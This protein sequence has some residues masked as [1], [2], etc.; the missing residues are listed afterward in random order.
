MCCCCL[1]S[2]SDFL[3]YIIALIFPPVAVLL[4]S[5][6]ASVDL[7]LNVCLTLL[8]FFPGLIHAFYYITMTSPIRGS[9][10]IYE[11]RWS[12]M[13]RDGSQQTRVY[14][15]IDEM[16]VPLNSN[17]SIENT[18]NSSEPEGSSNLSIEQ[19]LQNQKSHAVKMPSITQDIPPPP[20]PY[21]E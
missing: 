1:C 20:P 3:L 6:F 15:S 9:V 18:H 2:V 12:D 11:Q 16:R 7:L 4:R 5:G 19:A 13:E 8:G 17:N 10:Q 21:R 14:N